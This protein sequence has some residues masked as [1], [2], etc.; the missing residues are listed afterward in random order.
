M[1]ERVESANGEDAEPVGDVLGAV[2]QEKRHRREERV[3]RIEVGV[4][5][6]V[7]HT[8]SLAARGD[9]PDPKLAVVAAPTWNAP[10]DER[11]VDERRRATLDAD[12]EAVVLRIE[13]PVIRQVPARRAHVPE[14]VFHG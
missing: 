1:R 12:E 13:A 4:V 9:A 8:P 5:A 10:D 6:A 3:G 2:R 7:L 11:Q 14:V